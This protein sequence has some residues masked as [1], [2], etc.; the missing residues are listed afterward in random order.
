MAVQQGRFF[1]QI[2]SFAAMRA[3]L[4]VAEQV[5]RLG[6][7]DVGSNSVRLVVF[8]GAARSPA[9]FYNEKVLCGL[10]AGLRESGRLNPEGWERARAALRRFTVLAERMSLGGLSGVATAAVREARDG[11]AFC[12]MVLRE[13]GLRLR[14]LDGA[15]EARMAAQGV[16]LGWP[17][18]EGLV[19]DMGG[20][21]MELATVGRGRVLDG[22]TAPLGP[23]ALRE[24]ESGRSLTREIKG[25]LRRLRERLPDAMETLYLVGGSWRAIARV[26]M[27]RRSYPLS[28]LH[29]YVMQPEDAL[30][31]AKWITTEEPEALRELTG[32][33]LARLS[34]APLA[35]QV[36]IPLI[37]DFTPAAIRV[38]S[39]GLREGLLYEA[40]PEA[41]RRRDPLIE[42]ASQME[43]AM[44]RFPGFGLALDRWLAPLYA[45][46]EP[47]LARLVTAAC[48]LHDVNW[49]AHP[50][51]RAEIC[52]ETV[53][54]A[55]LSGLSHQERVFLGLALLHRYK[56]SK[57]AQI[58]RDIVALL[59][60]EEV[61]TA[62]ALGRALRLGAMLAGARIEGLEE[63][64]LERTD[65]ALVLTLMG[66]A[67]DLAGEVVE[68]RLAALAR[69]HGLSPEL[70][71]A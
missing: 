68:K 17:A 51:Y 29:D 54:R 9:Y 5:R 52:F 12:E 2:R 56:S 36:L 8:D 33:S 27:A 34:L 71:S 20:A 16:L 24:R 53:T 15:E 60:E 49:R 26:D 35:A 58:A 70:R 3:N 43:R 48:L 19:A 25:E 4:A 14:V 59:P 67:R 30:E 42:A 11:P 13:T 46:A 50:D 38:S 40:M 7:I 55:N 23:L 64:R 63:T 41:L 69:V 45:D 62:E 18:A 31:T 44:A 21:S 57:R 37:E 22:L 10:G 39:Y 47:R 65:D 32:S 6:V 66:E 61:A 1:D 28:V